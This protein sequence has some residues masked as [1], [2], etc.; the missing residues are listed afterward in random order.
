M[1]T[2]LSTSTIDYIL[3]RALFSSAAMLNQRYIESARLPHTIHTRDRCRSQTNT[4]SG[5][6]TINKTL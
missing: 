1:K 5:E 6:I 4:R 3:T 2:G